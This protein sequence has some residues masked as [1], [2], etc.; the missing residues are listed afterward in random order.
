M[1]EFLAHLHRQQGM[2]TLALQ[3]VIFTVGRSNEVL[4]AR[5][6]EIDESARVWNIPAERMKAARAHRVPLSDPALA[7]LKTVQPLAV[8]R[9]GQPE[10]DAPLFPVSDERC[11]YPPQQ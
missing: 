9:D 3:F 10:P 2:A 6:R 8:M 7:I 5:W 1:P 11:R 4:G